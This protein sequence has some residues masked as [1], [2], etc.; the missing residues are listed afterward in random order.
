MR[1]QG[2][3]DLG[4]RGRDRRRGVELAMTVRFAVDECRDDRD[5]AHLRVQERDRDRLPRG[6]YEPDL[7]GP[8]A[9][10]H[11]VVEPGGSA[12]GLEYDLAIAW[13]VERETQALG[14][15]S[16]RIVSGNDRDLGAEVTGD[17]AA[18]QTDR[19]GSDHADAHTGIDP[20]AVAR[21]E[22]DGERL[23]DRGVC[24]ADRTRQA[25]RARLGNNDLVRH[26]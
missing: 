1:D 20:G 18:Q 8:S 13:R 4:V 5:L 11:R 15:A 24:G 19:S 26:A 17:R 2:G 14:G 3:R 12:G 22:R 23:D 6:R 10:A 25:N 9:R 7:P 21:V 16:L